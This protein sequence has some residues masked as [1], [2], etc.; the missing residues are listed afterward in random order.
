MAGKLADLVIRARR[1]DDAAFIHDLASRVFSPYS[2]FPARVVA[3][4]LE[5]AGSDTRIAEIGATRVGFVVVEL[6]RYARS[7]GPWYK[8]VLARL[9]AIAVRPDAHGRGIGR[10]LVA[11][12]EAVARSASACSMSLATADDN[13]RARRLFMGAGFFVLARVPH[14]Y[15]RGQSAVLMQKP[16]I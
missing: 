4:M 9:N 10:L 15:A 16:L 11:E 13:T 7:F 6:E 12:A 14:F 1:S 8:P 2:H 3:S 5:E